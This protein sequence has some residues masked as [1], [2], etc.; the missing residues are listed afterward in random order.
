MIARKIVVFKLIAV[1]GKKF[2]LLCLLKISHATCAIN[3]EYLSF[4]CYDIFK[5]HPC[6]PSK[7]PMRYEPCTLKNNVV[8][9]S[10][11]YKVFSLQNA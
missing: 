10:L 9:I 3:P 11:Y 1:G 5:S 6:W 2:T 7:I 8:I 4:P